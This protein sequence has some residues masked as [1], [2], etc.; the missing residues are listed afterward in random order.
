MISISRNPTSLSSMSCSFA[1][2]QSR[3]SMT[4]S[5]Q[6]CFLLLAGQ[7]ALW[8]QLPEMNGSSSNGTQKDVWI[9][10]K[11][12]MKRSGSWC[13]ERRRQLMEDSC[14]TLMT[15]E[16]CASL[17]QRERLFVSPQA[18]SLDLNQTPFIL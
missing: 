13:L 18:L 2:F 11:Y 12:R 10:E 5:N 1:T 9:R 16:I 3:S 4:R 15:L 7:N 14:A 8:S 17:F 6:S